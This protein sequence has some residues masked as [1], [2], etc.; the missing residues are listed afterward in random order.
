MIIGFVI[1]HLWQSSC[2]V[3]VAELLTFMLRRNSPKIRF[4][5]WLSASLKFLIPFALL[6]SLGSVVPRPAWHSVSVPAPVFP[7]TVVQVAEPYSP[8]LDTTGPAQASLRW[9]PVAIGVLWSFGFF[10]V[11]L[12]RIRSWSKVRAAVRAGT[13]IDLP[14]AV[15]TLIT[16]GVEEP[17]IVGFLRPVLV[18]PA[19]ILQNLNPQQL[20]AILVHELWHVRR[21]DNLFAAMHM[22]V[23]AIF[24]FHPL[25]WW[26][27]SRMVKERELAC[28][29]EVLRTGCEPADYVEGILKVCRL[30]TDSRLPCVST[31][32]GADVKKRLRA[33]LAGNIGHDLNAGKKSVL[34]A[35]GLAAIG[36][37]ILIGAVN[38]PVIVAQISAPSAPS[39]ANSVQATKSE[40][41]H[42]QERTDRRSAVTPLAFEVASIKPVSPELG[43]GRR[44]IPR[45]P[46]GFAR[47]DMWTGREGPGTKDPGSIH[48]PVISLKSLLLNAYG[49]ENLQ[50]VVPDWSDTAWFAID[51]TMPPDTTR[52]QFELMLQNLLSERFKL[53][54]HREKKQSRG[55]ALTLAKNGPKMTESTI[56]PSEQTDTTREPFPPQPK[57]GSDAFLVPPRR[58]GVFQQAM[59]TRTHLVFQQVT[60]QDLANT[61]QAQ[62]KRPVVDAT[63]LTRQFDF[64]LTFSNGLEA[65]TT[66]GPTVNSAGLS[67]TPSPDIFEAISMQLGLKLDQRT[68]P[69]E[70]IVVDHLE[71][72][73]GAN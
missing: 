9:G 31:V 14:I 66:D 45:G 30:C 17:G 28:D 71:Q 21:R 4:R 44:V 32:T 43:G 47:I 35:I 37:P 51:A 73:A 70:M 58:A 23:E 69:V 11:V 26:V 33:I 61:L 36:I 41:E 8:V 16:T 10:A 40:T 15:K 34:T 59:G 53:K 22:V 19:Q 6:V 3:L 60:M 20:D 13:P 63:G 29:E 5:I 48:Y 65:G 50:V 64:S 25:V 18:L 42:I 46:A 68:I 56:G 67:D 24:W 38:A 7:V 54:V 39:A 12:A 72:T 52:E 57:I 49:V 1:N 2:F 62:L 27:G 55:Y